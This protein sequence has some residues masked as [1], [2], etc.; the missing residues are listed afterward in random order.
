MCV[1]VSVG[2]R[3]TI[4][5]VQTQYKFIIRTMLVRDSLYLFCV[6]E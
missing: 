3:E 2:K 6:F 5:Q 1:C 4:R